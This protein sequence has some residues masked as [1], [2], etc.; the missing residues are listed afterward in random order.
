MSL[1]VEQRLLN[2]QV[3]DF[4]PTIYTTGAYLIPLKVVFKGIEK[5]IWV[6]N[7]IDNDC[8]FD[9]KNCIVNVIADNK[10]DLIIHT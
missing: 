8:F 6:V 9:G 3:T 4:E 7:E 10:K 2:C 1:K 5:Y